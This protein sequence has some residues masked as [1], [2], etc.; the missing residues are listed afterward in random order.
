MLGKYLTAAALCISTASFA[1][2]LGLVNFNLCAQNSLLGKKE[3]EGFEALRNQMTTLIGDV[4][5]QLQE[6]SE[7]LQDADY[8]DTLSPQAEKELKEKFQTLSEEHARYQNQFYQ[9]MQQANMRLVQTVANS[10]QEAAKEVAK[11]H[12]L[13]YVLNKEACFFASDELDMTSE[14]I[15]LMDKKYELE[16]KEAKSQLAE[17][18]KE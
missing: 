9:L 6:I 4:E 10:V 7:K 5:K 13:K 12:K 11:K 8:L 14:V 2:D 3:Q 17:T 1:G 18:P 15:A 16:N